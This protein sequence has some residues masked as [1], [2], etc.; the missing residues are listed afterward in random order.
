M[1]EIYFPDPRGPPE[2]GH[3]EGRLGDRGGERDYADEQGRRG[4]GAEELEE[5]EVSVPLPNPV[6]LII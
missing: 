5:A 3:E 6:Q 4:G 2:P 1:I